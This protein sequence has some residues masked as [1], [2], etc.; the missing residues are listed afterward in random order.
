MRE[1]LMTLPLAT[2]KDIAKDKKVK[3]ITGMKK[4]DLIEVLSK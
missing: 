3:N 1:K 2:L 4:A